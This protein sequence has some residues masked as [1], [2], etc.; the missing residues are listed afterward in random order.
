MVRFKGRV[1]V[2]DCFIGL[3]CVVG[4]SNGGHAVG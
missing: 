1:G 3:V 2:E 4:E